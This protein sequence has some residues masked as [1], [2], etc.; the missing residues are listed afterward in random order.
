MG[1]FPLIS[2]YMLWLMCIHIHEHTYIHKHRLYTYT[3]HPHHICTRC[4]HIIHMSQT[5]KIHITC[6]PYTLK[7]HTYTSYTQDLSQFRWRAGSEL[8]LLLQRCHDVLLCEM[9]QNV[10]YSMILSSHRKREGGKPINV[11][12][13]RGYDK[14]GQSHGRV[15]QL[16][17]PSGK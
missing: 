12:P 3:I 2:T 4:T 7:S 9:I 10:C 1:S 11:H 6:I 13:D 14:L 15:N 17:L 16:L 8:Y 5:Y